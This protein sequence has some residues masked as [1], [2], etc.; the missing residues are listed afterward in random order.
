[1][2][3]NNQDAIT[4]LGDGGGITSAELYD[5]AK[6]MGAQ[7][8]AA[9]A[10]VDK[11]KASVRTFGLGW[12]VAHTATESGDRTFLSSTGPTPLAAVLDAM[13]KEKG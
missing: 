6:R 12:A 10:W 9:W 1:M 11:R 5:E 4:I 3:L 7:A 8:L 2:A 13:E